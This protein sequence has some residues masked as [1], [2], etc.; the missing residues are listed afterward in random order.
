MDTWTEESLGK[1]ADELAKIN[2]TLKATSEILDK[3]S[4]HYDGVV[5]EMTE[6]VQRS[7]RYGRMAE[8]QTEAQTEAERVGHN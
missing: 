1:I 7:N 2:N 5:G 6:N 3:I 4:K 8:A